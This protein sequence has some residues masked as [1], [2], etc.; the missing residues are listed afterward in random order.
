MANIRRVN[1][2]TERIKRN[3]LHPKH[4]HF[5]HQSSTNTTVDQAASYLGPNGIKRKNPHNLGFI[6]PNNIKRIDRRNLNR[7]TS[8]QSQHTDVTNKKPQH[9]IHQ[10][11]SYIVVVPD[12][13]SGRLSSHDKDVLGFARQLASK[14]ETSI[15]VMAITFGPH[16]ETNWQQVGVDRLVELTDAVFS[17]YCPEAKIAALSKLEQ[18]L[19]VQHFLLPDSIDGGADIGRRL[20][21]QLQIRPVT[22][23]WKATDETI[24]CRA[25]ASTQDLRKTLSKVMLLDAEIAEPVQETDYAASHFVLDQADLH[26]PKI[27]YQIRDQGMLPVNPAEIGLAEAPFILAAGNG[28]HKWEVFH[29]A[30]HLLGATEGA[31]RVAVDEGFMPRHRQVGATGT[32]V[33]ARVYIA[34]GISGAVQHL[35]GIAQVDKVIAINTNPRCDMVKRADLSIIANSDDILQ[36]LINAVAKPP[37]SAHSATNSSSAKTQRQSEHA[38]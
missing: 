32:W 11:N 38:I 10:P 16:K 33:N 31:S 37:L 26:H 15:A 17:G 34:V 23:G 22:H 13:T 36:A 30:A 2:H 18:H 1:P 14:D 27:T 12:L 35:Q 8:A 21:A 25:A 28:V 29:K 4:A 7:N 19:N 24:L 20:A 3:R 9:I 6:G 5:S